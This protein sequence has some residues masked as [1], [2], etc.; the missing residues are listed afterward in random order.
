[1]PS[2]LS[3]SFK[4][5]THGGF[6]VK[7]C[8]GETAAINTINRN[9]AAR[10]LPAWLKGDPS[11][12]G[13]SPPAPDAAEPSTCSWGLPCRHWQRG[14]HFWMLRV[15][16]RLTLG[17]CT[18]QSISSTR[19]SRASLTTPVAILGTTPRVNGEFALAGKQEPPR[20]LQGGAAYLNRKVIQEVL[21]PRSSW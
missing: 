14:S 5:Y 11:S 16:R 9:P 8:Q 4:N 3:V 15:M 12:Q 20:D 17:N 10:G 7:K 1:M 2:F 21:F 18:E 6:W 19:P 13:S